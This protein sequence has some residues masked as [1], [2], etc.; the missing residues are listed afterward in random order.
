M[1][2]IEGFRIEDNGTEVIFETTLGEIRCEIPPD[3][4]DEYWDAI[5]ALDDAREKMKAGDQSD[6]GPAFQRIKP[7]LIELLQPLAHN[8]EWN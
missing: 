8:V 4:L 5:H 1:G 7:M 6:I 3:R 2:R